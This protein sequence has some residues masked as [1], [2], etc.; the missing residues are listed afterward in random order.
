MPTR[1]RKPLFSRPMF[2]PL[3]AL[4]VMFCV[5]TLHAK[6]GARKSPD[7]VPGLKSHIHIRHLPLPQ[8]AVNHQFLGVHVAEDPTGGYWVCWHDSA[9]DKLSSR[10]QHLND[11]MLPDQP[12]IDLPER[13]V[14]GMFGHADG[15]LA[16]A[17]GARMGPEVKGNHAPGPPVANTLLL[18]K[19]SKG[20]MV[21]E[22]KVRG[23]E[24]YEENNIWLLVDGTAPNVSVSFNGKMYGLFY[25][26]GKMF[27]GR[28]VHQADEFI[29]LDP[30]GKII[31]KSRLTWISS[32]SFW[33]SSI[34]GADGDI[35]G[36]TVSDPQPWG[37]RLGNFTATPGQAQKLTMIFPSGSMR[38][39]ARNIGEPIRP[40]PIFRM[41]RGYG[42]AGATYINPAALQ[43]P[44]HGSRLPVLVRFDEAGQSETIYLDDKPVDDLIV[45][46][47]RLG[48]NHVAVMQASGQGGRA[49]V[50]GAYPTKMHILDERG[51]VAHD[52]V[53]VPAPLTFGSHP[54]TM[55]NGDV[56]WAG[57]A[58]DHTTVNDA[59]KLYVV[60][61]R[62]PE[63]KSVAGKTPTRVLPQT[64]AQGRMRLA[65][66]LVEKGDIPRARSI[67]QLLLREHPNSPEA[68]LAK[69]WL[70][71]D[72]KESLDEP[73]P[74]AQPE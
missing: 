35:Y 67:L 70:E 13:S 33:M 57:I 56:L 23:G 55:G 18:R 45:T 6:D 22:T 34:V 11:Q 69:R 61:I 14:Q 16:L 50:F 40:G 68:A 26:I 58:D 64:P 3:A 71:S 25:C 12:M 54:A 72:G 24:G 37:L 43:N 9:G 2:T 65:K 32:H 19:I 73:P 53:E 74:A 48:P 63:A 21:F 39:T 47:T 36:I 1:R 29:A 62:W 20:K 60:R 46:G 15:S 51:R 52:P 31:E 59:T 10:V 66:Q 28:D 5:S 42:I 41:R 17:L 38:E 44:V 49:N 7:P 8:R 27:P 4:L 30:A